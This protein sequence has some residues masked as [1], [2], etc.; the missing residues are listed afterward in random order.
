MLDP[1]LVLWNYASHPEQQKKKM[2]EKLILDISDSQIVITHDA[3]Q[4]LIKEGYNYNII[5]SKLYELIWSKKLEYPY[6]NIIYY[7]GKDT[8]KKKETSMSL[9]PFSKNTIT[10]TT[11]INPIIYYMEEDI[12]QQKIS[13]QKPYNVFILRAKELVLKTLN[14]YSEFNY[15]LFKKVI[16]EEL[17]ICY[18]LH[19]DIIKDILPNSYKNGLYIGFNWGSFN[20]FPNF[21]ILTPHISLSKN[22]LENIYEHY[23][24][25]GNP[26]LIPLPKQYNLGETN[27]YDIIFYSALDMKTYLDL[28]IEQFVKQNLLIDLN[29]LLSRHKVTHL[30]ILLF[31]ELIKYHKQVNEFVLLHISYYGYTLVKNMVLDTFVLFQFHKTDDDT[32]KKEIE[33]LL[34][35]NPLYNTLKK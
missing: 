29:K 17:K 8:F 10:Y 31:S 22:K 1:L 32:K 21:T 18:V 25:K 9:Y 13:G 35:A 6:D 27:Q 3:L 16:R 7:L 4:K 2:H 23:K 19:P 34:K 30:F 15:K 5:S 28:N 20:I 33:S 14:L 26:K 12:I 11:I 24:S